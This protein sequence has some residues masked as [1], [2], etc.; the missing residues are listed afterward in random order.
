MVDNNLHRL[1]VQLKLAVNR[2]RLLQQKKDAI[3]KQQRRELATLVETGRVEFARIRCEH[4]IQEDINVEMLSMI[5][6]YCELL[7][8]R[9]GLLDSRYV[10][11]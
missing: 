8:A 6:L 7:L 11:D 9:F 5:E 2:L 4:V 10:V 3:A 1:K